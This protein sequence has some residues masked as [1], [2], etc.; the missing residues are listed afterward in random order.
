VSGCRGSLRPSAQRSDGPEAQIETGTLSPH[1]N[2]P[3]ALCPE[4]NAPGNFVTAPHGPAA[5]SRLGSPQS[6]QDHKRGD[7]MSVPIGKIDK[8]SLRAL[9]P[10]SPT[11]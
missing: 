8:P 10:G 4:H 5:G 9:G 11:S 6:Q 3:E 2:P 7:S 1:H